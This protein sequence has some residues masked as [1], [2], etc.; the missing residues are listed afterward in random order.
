M[1][2]FLLILFFPILIFSQVKWDYKSENKVE[3]ISFKL[4]NNN[5]LLPI[6]LNGLSLN[7]ILD[8]GS[9]VNLLF[10]IP[11]KDSLVLKKSKNLKITGPGLKEPLNA[12][13]TEDNHLE[14][15]NMASKN[16]QIIIL[17]DGV[18]DFLSNS[19]ES[20]H[21]ILGADF[22][23]DNLVDIDYVTK[24]IKVSKNTNLKFLKNVRKRKK[25][26]FELLFNKPFLDIT[27]SIDNSKEEKLKMLI[28]TGL[29]DG[30]WLFDKSELTTERKN[31][32]DFLGSSLGGEIYGNKSRFKNF[33]FSD[34]EFVNP[35][36]SFP[37]TLY[38]SF[39]NVNTR[40]NNGSI[41][42]DVLKRFKI[43]FDYENKAIYLS[44]NSNYDD[45]FRYNIAGIDLIISG[46]D[47]YQEKEYLVSNGYKS[48]TKD[49]STNNANSFSFYGSENYVIN[50]KK[51]PKY[52]IN[53]IRKNSVANRA[54]LLKGDK[55]VSING[56]G[57]LSTNL[58]KYSDYFHGMKGDYLKMIIERNGVS[59]DFE[60][61]LKDEL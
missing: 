53:N 44:K 34:F 2:K 57:Y 8:T 28:D 5:I 18:Q 46:Y 40:I 9:P 37:D 25:I 58:E 33:K 15:G 50:I 51:K 4:T 1:N 19:N 24:K 55:I 11:E 31:I 10:N 23:L 20:I 22:F 13:S 59:M 49:K 7:F 56:Q 41:G 6:K 3:K 35:I 42:G 12:I 14:I 29:S 45:P 17:E 61:F 16:I 30:L 54:G 39:K 26:N 27:L 36:I 38:F 48:T 43:M 47:I 32:T 52:V 21:G 60:L